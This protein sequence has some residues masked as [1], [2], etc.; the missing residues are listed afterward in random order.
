MQNTKLF[1][2]FIISVKLLGYHTLPGPRDMYVLNA[3]LKQALRYYRFYV[4]NLPTRNSVRFG[5]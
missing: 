2:I 4:V 3:Y 5:I 1:Y